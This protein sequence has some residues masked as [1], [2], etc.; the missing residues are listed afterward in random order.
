[1]TSAISSDSLQMIE[2]LLNMIEKRSLAYH[3]MRP[4]LITRKKKKKRMSKFRDLEDYFMMGK[5]TCSDYTLFS[6]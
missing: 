1:M 3:K 6:F 5:L 2:E 4:S